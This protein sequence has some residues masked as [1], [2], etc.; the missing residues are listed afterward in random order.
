[1]SRTGPI[2]EELPDD[3]DIHPGNT[4]ASSSSSSTCATS[5]GQGAVRRGF[6]NK[7]TARTEDSNKPSEAATANAVRAADVLSSAGVS[8][9][10]A[11]ASKMKESDSG[12]ASSDLLLEGLRSR[13]RSAAADATERIRQNAEDA[14]KEKKAIDEAL[15]ALQVKWPSAQT[16]ERA[17]KAAK[18]IDNTLAEMRGFANDSRRLRC[19]DEKRAIAELRKGAED[20]INRVSKVAEDSKA[21]QESGKDKGKAA[22]IAFHALPLT[23]K[24]RILVDEK[25]GLSLLLAF[26]FAGMALMYLFGLEVVSALNCG[27]R[28]G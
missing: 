11:A 20:V 15:T 9:G 21:A 4:K 3:Y 5:E 22:V 19:G 12:E 6:F 14:A 7:E 16:K 28:C 13:L 27:W 1:M 24:L 10:F 18:E 8:S 2:I 25:V 17:A 26:F 23:A